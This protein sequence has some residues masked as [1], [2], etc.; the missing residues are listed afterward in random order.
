MLLTTKPV[1]SP[2]LRTAALLAGVLTATAAEAQ[3]PVYPSPSWPTAT[4]ESQ[5]LDSTALQN[6][7]TS[8]PWPINQGPLIV[9]A[10]GHEV[11]SIGDVTAPQDLFSCSKVI[12]AML[13]ARAKQLG[14]IG[15]LDEFVPN[16]PRGPWGPGYPGDS[17]FRRFITMTSD[18]NLTPYHPVGGQYAY[19]NNGVEHYGEH[20]GQ[21]YFGAGPD[22]MDVAVDAAIFSQIGREDGI[23]FVGQYGGWFGGLQISARDLARIGYLL[24]REGQWNGN[25][26]LD[27]EIPQGLFQGQ[28]PV[29][30]QRY[31]STN[32]NENS[33]WNQQTV[34]DLLG[35]DEW[36]YGMWRVGDLKADKTWRTAAAEGFRGKRLILF[37]K[38]SLPNSQLEVVLVNL[39]NPNNEGPAS[40][41]YRDAIVSAVQTLPAHPDQDLDCVTTS[42][43]DGEFGRLTPTF[44]DVCVE[45]EDLVLTGSSRMVLPD[46]TMKDGHALIRLPEGL[47]TP[48]TWAGLTFRASQPNDGAF[49]PN[50]TQS[51][52]RLR[53][54]PQGQLV[55]D[56]LRSVNGV[57]QPTT[58]NIPTILPTATMDVFAS[59]VGDRLFCRVNGI[60]VL[61]GGLIGDFH[62]NVDGY[63]A[64]QTGGSSAMDTV[65]VGLFSATDATA[66]AAQV[67]VDSQGRQ[68][69]S[70]LKP[71]LLFTFDPN[72]RIFFG[73]LPGDLGDFAFLVQFLWPQVLAFGPDHLVVRQNLDLP[74][75]LSLDTSI[76]LEFNG[77][78]EGEY[79]R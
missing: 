16:S 59:L 36:S 33:Q 72:F 78:R 47:P 22:Q 40:S 12:T 25:Q 52:L 45:G 20:L 77:R 65:R 13:A 2:K 34:T 11:F 31:Q 17:S 29:T 68:T 32:P 58:L 27:P 79:V 15:S 67:E 42:F 61:G 51:T 7:L 64:L 30:A 74:A 37:P 60:P 70:F 9:I 69:I 71:D 53:H 41:V 4:P 1:R 5:G 21:T 49:E 3:P 18:Y 46:T 24:L 8:L 62:P 50:G 54:T 23:G 55:V 75:L 26:V 28:I 56:V 48:G 14:H 73:T 6:A 43:A 35:P 19:S 57:V 38:G 39:P 44:G 63:V 10:N 76:V 66:S